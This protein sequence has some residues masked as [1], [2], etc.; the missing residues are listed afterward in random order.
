MASNWCSKYFAGRICQYIIYSILKQCFI[1]ICS[2]FLTFLRIFFHYSYI[3]FVQYCR[4][5]ICID[6]TY[7]WRLCR[8]V[9]RLWIY[10]LGEQTLPCKHLL[11]IS[12]RGSGGGD[13]LINI[14]LTCGEPTAAYA[15]ARRWWRAPR[16]RRRW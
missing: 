14:R 13:S 12:A 9:H 3:A 1:N 15:P 16:C 11:Q 2:F 10:L 6:I 4:F 7:I 8:Y 5:S